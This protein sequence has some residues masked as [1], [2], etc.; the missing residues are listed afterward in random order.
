MIPL[1]ESNIHGGISSVMGDRWVKLDET[2]NILLIDANKLNGHSMSQTLAYYATKFVRKNNLED[3]SSTPDG[4]D[5]G[6]FVGV[7][8]LY[9]SNIKERT[10]NFPF[11][12]EN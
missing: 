5:V 1:L 11:C 4:S 2:K 12:T 10:K 3:I 9:S 8:L 6:Y 7:D